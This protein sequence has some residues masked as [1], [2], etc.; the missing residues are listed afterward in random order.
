MRF[1]VRL[2]KSA[3]GHVVRNKSAQEERND[4]ECGK[5]SPLPMQRIGDCFDAEPSGRMF[6]VN[7]CYTASLLFCNGLAAR[8]SR[9][10]RSQRSQ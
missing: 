4:L 2:C 5:I 9:S 3:N 10:E 1:N 6:L 7:L 8:S